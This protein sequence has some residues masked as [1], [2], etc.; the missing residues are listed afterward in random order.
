MSDF[1]KLDLRIGTVVKCE[2]VAKSDKLLHE[3]INI[4]NDRLLSVV[5]GIA[6]YY[7]P[8]EMLG[9]QVV[10]LCNLP[11]RKLK[12]IVSE[13]MLLTAENP[14]G[15]IRLLTVADKVQDGAIIA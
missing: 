10:L 3:T 13:A 8:E 11:A 9:K 15:S 12:G 5:S 1:A 7:T 14:D 4:G 2:R 6:R